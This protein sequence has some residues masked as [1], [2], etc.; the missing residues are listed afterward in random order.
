MAQFVNQGNKGFPANTTIGEYL[1]VTITPAG[2]AA[3]IV[4]GTPVVTLAGIADEDIGVTTRA[5]FTT[6][7][8]VGGTQSGYV[9]VR[10]RSAGGTSQYTANGAILCGANV[11]TAAAGLISSSAASTSTLIGLALQSATNSGDIIEILP[12]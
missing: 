8:L 2:A 4:Q 11:Y 7:N 10:L 3:T 5:V 9:D 12:L 6:T 1:R